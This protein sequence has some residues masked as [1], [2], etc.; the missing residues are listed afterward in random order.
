[1]IDILKSV[2]ITLNLFFFPRSIKHLFRGTIFF[3]VETFLIVDI[4]LKNKCFVYMSVTLAHKFQYHRNHL[5]VKCPVFYFQLSFIQCKFL[6]H[7]LFH[8]LLTFRVSI[9]KKMFNSMVFH[10]FYCILILLI[11]FKC[12]Q[13]LEMFKPFVI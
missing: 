11:I 1:M 12:M 7:F 13:M 8:Y 2:Y 10:R 5:D 9:L 3:T 4:V 6:F